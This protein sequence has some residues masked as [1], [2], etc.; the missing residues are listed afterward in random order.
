MVDLQETPAT[1]PEDY[2]G[3]LRIG[4]QIT[5]AILVAVG[6]GGGVVANL[7]AHIMAPSSGLTLLWV[8]VYPTMG[9]YSLAILGMGLFA[10]LF[11]VVLWILGR[12]SPRGPF[13]LPGYDYSTENRP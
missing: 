13:V 11:G 6:W 1:P 8:H 3:D 9:A 4:W 7:V 10:G 12:S 2:G 5:G